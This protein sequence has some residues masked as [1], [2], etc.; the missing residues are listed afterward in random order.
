MAKSSKRVNRAS[1][2]R[3]KTASRSKVTKKKSKKKAAKKASAK[4][5]VPRGSDVDDYIENAAAFAQPILKKIRTAH[6]KASRDLV[7]T[8]KWG[9]P[10]FDFNGIVSGMAA[11]KNH[12]SFGFWKSKLMSDP[13]KLFMESPRASMCH[14]KFAQVD[15]LPD[16][17]VLIA[18]IKEAMALNQPTQVAAQSV[19]RA[20]KK[21]KITASSLAVPPDLMAQLKK[22]AN[23]KARKT[24][25][26]FPPSK[27]KDY[28]EWLTEAKREETRAR[29][30]ATTVEWLNEGKARHWKYANC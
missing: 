24:F 15:E 30:L 22:P 18:Y 17:K 27:R 29:R 16:E 19:A 20:K 1:T 9:V 3:K 14:M 12:V 26:E 11:F 10:H 5:V 4:M 2:Q 8:I 13:N 28:I 7:E 21:K 6:R 23:K 25:E